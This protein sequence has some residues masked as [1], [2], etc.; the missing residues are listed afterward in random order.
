MSLRKPEA[1]PVPQA[2]ESTNRS[3]QCWYC[4][5]YHMNR[6][7]PVRK[8]AKQE[9]QAG[10]KAI[11][12]PLSIPRP[13]ENQRSRLSTA[14]RSRRQLLRVL[15]QF[16]GHDIHALYDTAASDNF[17]HARYLSEIQCRSLKKYSQNVNL[18]MEGMEMEII[19]EISLD[20]SI[21]GQTMTS[22]FLVSDA[23]RDPMILGIPWSEDQEAI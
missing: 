16:T 4:P 5:A 8:K 23:M 18:A 1:K 22:S 19:G 17:M 2:K 14:T 12:G 7:C 21:Q 13:P 20:Y 6:D 11:N 15:V 10:P 3:P 9:E